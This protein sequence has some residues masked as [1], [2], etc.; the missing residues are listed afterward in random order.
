ML[1]KI[2]DL[3]IAIVK[4][5]AIAFFFAT[6]I[7]IIVSPFIKEKTERVFSLINNFAAQ[8][9]IGKKEEIKF[10]TLEKKLANYPP[11][12]TIFANL[13]IEEIGLNQSIVHGDDLNIL[14]VNI[15]H[16]P[17][18]YFPGE[19]GSI[20]I[21]A[22]NSK[23]HF[24]YLPKLKKGSEII[25]T[26]DY[27]IFTYKV[28]SKKIIKADDIDSL[29]INKKKEILMMYTCYPVGAIGYKAQRYVVYAELIN[30][31]YIGDKYE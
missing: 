7:V 14:K 13:K 26:T 8:G 9:T 22:H 23:K 30:A 11:Y 2:I 25:I 15:G 20:I 28:H 16:F 1:K 6:L 3:I 29:P 31:E 24:M 10:D 18:S 21:A 17:G 12:G 4:Q 27:G 19:G 5:L